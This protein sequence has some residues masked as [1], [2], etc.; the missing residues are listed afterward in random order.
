MRCSEMCFI[1]SQFLI[2]SA[3]AIGY[4]YPPKLLLSLTYTYLVHQFL[5]TWM[6]VLK[7]THQLRYRLQGR[8]SDSVLRPWLGYWYAVS[9][10]RFSRSSSRT[11]T[12]AMRTYAIFG[13]S[14]W[15]LAYF[16]ILGTACMALDIVS[17]GDRGLPEACH[18]IFLTDYE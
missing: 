16:T 3:P 12:F 14:R 11:V 6:L 18:Q 1:C 15:I 4:V 2:S 10:N 13:K 17:T 8:G 5:F 9:L 7:Y